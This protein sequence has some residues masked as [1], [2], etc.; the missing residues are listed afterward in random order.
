MDE[1]TQDHTQTPPATAEFTTPPQAPDSYESNPF[2]VVAKGIVSI[3]HYNPGTAL[4]MIAVLLTA[5]VVAA[6]VLIV[7]FIFIHGLLFGLIFGLLL[8]L[9]YLVFL[10]VSVG[11][12][13]HI[14]SASIR[15]QKTTVRASLSRAL[16]RLLPLVGLSLML[17]IVVI[18]GFVLLIVPGFFLLGRLSLSTVVLMEENLGPIAAMKRSWKLTDKH[19]MEMLGAL[20]AAQLIGLGG[21]GLLTPTISVAPLFGR[22]ADLRAL[23]QS[24]AAVRPKVHWLNYLALF[25]TIPLIAAVVLLSALAHNIKPPTPSQTIP[26]QNMNMNPYQGPSPEGG[27]TGPGTLGSGTT[28]LGSGTG[29]PTFNYPTTQ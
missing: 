29:T 5:L 27:S 16:N 4:V 28:N 23:E 17:G 13:L 19:V 15:G 18:I 1:T 24:G 26:S 12:Y 6:L 3:L 22:Y 14:G 21:A 10:G 11:S 9:A 20:F 7:P 2:L 8:I 25:I